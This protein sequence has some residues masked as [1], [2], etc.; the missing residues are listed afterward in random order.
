MKRLLLVM[1]LM[2]VVALAFYGTANAIGGVCSNCHTMHN[3]Q[4]GVTAA[5]NDTLLKSA[6]ECLGCHAGTGVTGAPIIDES[7]GA[8]MPSG[9]SFNVDYA[10]SS[11]YTHNVKEFVDAS[12]HAAGAGMVDT[13]WVNTPPGGTALAT[14]LQCAGTVGC[15]GDGSQAGS[16]DAVKGMHH[17]TKTTYKFLFVGGSTAAPIG[18]TSSANYEV[19]GATA[20]N[21]NLYSAESGESISTFCNNCHDDFHGTGATETGGIASPW[22]RHPTDY[23]LTASMASAT[24]DYATTPWAFTATDLSGMSTTTAAGYTAAN[25]QVM[26]L[27]CHRAHASNQPD[28]LR[29]D[30]ST[31]DAG[32]GGTTGCLNCHVSQR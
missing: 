24:A 18:G 22:K 8:N 9:G 15:H 1:S 4:D 5:G 19:G 25:A 32:G 21:H 14:Q 7:L 20:A 23:A 12:M 27:S 31:M 26:C 2:V 13:K 28:L 29:F 10:T 11:T 3:S 17:A 30:Y 16:T 6:T